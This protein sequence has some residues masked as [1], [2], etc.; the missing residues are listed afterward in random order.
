MLKQQGG[1]PRRVQ[2][3]PNLTDTRLKDT[4]HTHSP[5][6]GTQTKE[7][8]R[9]TSRTPCQRSKGKLPSDRRVTGCSPNARRSMLRRP[10]ELATKGGP[11]QPWANL[12]VREKLYD[13]Q[14]EQKTPPG[15]VQRW[16]GRS[17]LG[18]Q[19]PETEPPRKHRQHRS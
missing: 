7:E 17:G 11:R 10:A 6:E 13:P 3:E 2:E 15:I 12:K 1:K 19:A 5:A 9:S 14:M 4:T 16:W 8:S 18:R